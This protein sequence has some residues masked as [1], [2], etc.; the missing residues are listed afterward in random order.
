MAQTYTPKIRL[1]G[2]AGPAT[3]YDLS[4]YTYVTVQVP[5]YEALFTESEML[6]RSVKTTRYG[7]RVGVQLNFEFPNSAS[8]NE[9]EL[10]ETILSRAQDDNWMVELSLDGGSNY[11]E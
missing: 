11:K 5:S 8:A 6:D 2:P 9:T 10:A 7:Y 1:T 3:T 4:A